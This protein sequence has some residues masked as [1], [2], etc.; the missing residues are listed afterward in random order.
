VENESSD[1]SAV[2]DEEDEEDEVIETDTQ[3]KKNAEKSATFA[4][5]ILESDEEEDEDDEDDEGGVE[6]VEWT[7]DGE[8]YLVDE[9]SNIVYSVETQEIVG[10]RVKKSGAWKLIEE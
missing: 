9:E 8:D 7:F 5:Q 3:I 2:T 1:Y 6:V 4:E 10:K